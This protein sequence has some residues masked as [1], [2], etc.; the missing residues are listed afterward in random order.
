MPALGLLRAKKRFSMFNE[1][2]IQETLTRRE[3]EVLGLLVQRKSNIQIAEELVISIATVKT[4]VSNIL[5]KLH[6]NSRYEVTWHV[7]NKDKQNILLKKKDEVKTQYSNREQI[8]L[9]KE[10]SDVEIQYP[11][12]YN[13][14]KPEV[15][16]LLTKKELSVFIFLARKEIATLSNKMLAQRLEMAESTLKKH[17]NRIY[18]KLNTNNRMAT[19]ILAM[20]LIRDIEKTDIST[21]KKRAQS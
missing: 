6:V 12:E 21:Y 5:A 13:S 10:L 15:W 3:F 7:I 11:I 9:S 4:H 8:A 20:D 17:L 14:I 19:S 18:E 1:D 16:E 2:P